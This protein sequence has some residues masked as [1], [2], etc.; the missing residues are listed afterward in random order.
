MNRY[1][2]CD[3]LL[4]ILA[5]HSKKVS[6]KNEEEWFNDFSFRFLEVL[7]DHDNLCEKCL[8][9]FYKLEKEVRK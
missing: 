8:H 7:K 2:K 5:G 4:D 1:I 9:F 3:N 6:S